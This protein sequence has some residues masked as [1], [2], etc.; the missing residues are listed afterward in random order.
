EGGWGW[1][2]VLGCH[3]QHII[4]GGFERSDGVLFLKLMSK[5]NGTA[6]ATSWVC[7]LSSTVRLMIGPLAS[8]MCNR[9]T[10]RY[11]TFVGAVLF[12]VGVLLSGL[13]PSLVYLYF[14]YGVLGGI[15]RSLSYTP[16]LLIV[17]LY[18]DKKRGLASGISSAGVGIGTFL[19]P[20]V[21]EILFE[22]FDFFG[23]F[24]ILSAIPLNLCI[25]AMLFRPLYIHHSIITTENTTTS[26]ATQTD[27]EMGK[28]SLQKFYMKYIKPQKTETNQRKLI[29]FSLLKIPSFLFFC[30]GIAIFTASF[31]S[32]FTFLPALAKANGCTEREAALVMS[33]TGIV[34]TV[35][36]IGAGFLL[37]LGPIKPFR[38][39]VY[40]VVMFVIVLV[41]FLCPQAEG[42]LE[43]CLVGCVYGLLTGGYISQKSV[44][45]V[46]ILG[47]DKI[48]HSF[49]LMIFFQGLGTLVGPPLS[50]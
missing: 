39:V 10:C 3:L 15:G 16:G 33:V 27:P 21:F 38:P 18:F 34:D 13:A 8:A 46:D 28:N 11:T 43:Y 1:F 42:F 6:S 30:I 14:T 35:S 45:I 48:S 2:V 31:K 23:A 32:A 41:T 50:G 17:G 4:I 36:R 29:D 5:F 47:A 40:N 19:L 49:G 7:S 44:I 20:L 26:T 25:C 12:A 9:F 22:E 37:E 24:L